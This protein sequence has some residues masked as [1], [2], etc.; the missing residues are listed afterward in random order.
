MRGSN[1]IQRRGIYWYY[2]AQERAG[3]REAKMQKPNFQNS[4]FKNYQCRCM[5]TVCFGLGMSLSCFCPTGLTLFLCA[6]I[7]VAL[8][9]SLLRH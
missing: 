3:R 8:G 9:F 1:T 6:V 2:Q 5:C 4:C 7:M